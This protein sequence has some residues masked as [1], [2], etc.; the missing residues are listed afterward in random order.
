M[1]YMIANFRIRSG[2]GGVDKPSNPPG[3]DIY[4]EI[5]RSKFKVQLKKIVAAGLP[6][7]NAA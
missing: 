6:V 7:Y 3:N 4:Q 5:K 2:I 1:I